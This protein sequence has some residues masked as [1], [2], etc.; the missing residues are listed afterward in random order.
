MKTKFLK[1]F[2][3]FN[4]FVPLSFKT[5]QCIVLFGEIGEGEVTFYLVVYICVP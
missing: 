5:D 4:F 3:S 1:I 2:D